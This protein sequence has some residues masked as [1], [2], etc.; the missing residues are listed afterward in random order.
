MLFCVLERPNR[1]RYPEKSG[2]IM[3]PSC[4]CRVEEFVEVSEGYQMDDCGPW[5]WRCSFS[6]RYFATTTSPS[7]SIT[8]F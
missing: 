5:A 6:R 4:C 2:K 8:V 3:N 7:H 1:H